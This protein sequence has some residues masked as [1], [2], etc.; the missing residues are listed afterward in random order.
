MFRFC[1]VFSCALILLLIWTGTGRAYAQK[2][3]RTIREGVGW[4]RFLVGASANSLIDAFG[5]PDKT[6]SGRMMRWDKLGLN[7]LL[8]DKDEVIELRFEKRFKGVTASGVSVRHAGRQG[9]QDLRRCRKNGLARRRHE[10]YL[11][12]TGHP[13]L[14]SRQCRLSDCDLSSAGIERVGRPRPRF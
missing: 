12:F 14:V 13:D 10:I 2:T 9:P 4:D 8:N 6:S 5:Y 3:Q 11:A 1:R 7:C